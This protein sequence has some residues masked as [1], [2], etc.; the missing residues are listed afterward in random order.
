VLLRHPVPCDCRLAQAA[1]ANL[2]LIGNAAVT[3]EIIGALWPCTGWPTWRPG[4]SLTLPV[5]APTVILYGVEMLG[6]TDQSRLSEWLESRPRRAQ[7]VSTST[8][9]L[10]P[11]AG[12]NRFSPTLYYRLNTICVD[13]RESVRAR[14]MS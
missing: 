7:V 9:P 10:L 14:A 5:D 4:Q 13:L 3:G 2:L 1:G 6:R 12:D 11:G 8:V